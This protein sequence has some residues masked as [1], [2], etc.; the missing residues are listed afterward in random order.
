LGSSARRIY[1]IG[2]LILSP[3]RRLVLEARGVSPIDLAPLVSDIEENEKAGVALGHFLDFLIKSRPKPATEWRSGMTTSLPTMLSNRTLDAASLSA[4]LKRMTAIWRNE[5]EAYPGWLVCPPTDRTHLSL[6]C[7]YNEDLVRRAFEAVSERERAESLYEVAWRRDLAFAPLS[8]WLRDA[9]SAVVTQNTSTL[10]RRQRCEIGAILA[11]DAREERDTSLFERWMA[12]LQT[13]GTTDEDV[14]ATCAYEKSLFARNQLDFSSLTRLIPTIAGQDPIWKIR[15]AALYCDLG[16]AEKAKQLAIE[17]VQEARNRYMRDRKS[18]WNI[19][20]LAWA[21]FLA[22]AVRFTPPQKIVADPLMDSTGWSG[23]LSANECDPWD[24][25]SNLDRE[26]SDAFRSRIDRSRSRRPSFDAGVYS[27]TVSLGSYSTAV[28]AFD[29]LRLPERVGLPS[30]AGLVNVMRSRFSQALELSDTWTEQDLLLGLRIL[31]VSDKLIERL[32][33]RIEVARMPL[34]TVENLIRAIWKAVAFG[35]GRFAAITDAAS[36]NVA[37]YWIERVGV[38]VEILSHLVIHLTGEKAVAAFRE[39]AAL[40]E[41]HDWTC[42]VLFEPLRHLLE[43]SCEAVSPSDL[44]GLVPDIL[45]VPLPDERGI[46][47]ASGGASV[48]NDWPELTQHLPAPTTRPANSAEFTRRVGELIS[49][50]NVGDSLTRERAMVRLGWLCWKGGVLTSTEVASFSEAVWSKREPSGFPVGFQGHPEIFFDFPT[51]D[52]N[53]EL[54]ALFRSSV[55]NSAFSGVI[56]QQTIHAITRATRLR[57]DG[58]RGFE[59]DSDEAVK[60]FDILSVWTPDK[61]VKW[62]MGGDEK[63]GEVIARALAWAV[64]PFITPGAL[65]NERAERLLTAIENGPLNTAVL[66]LPQIVRLQ[67]SYENRAIELIRKAVLDREETPVGYGLGAIHDWHRLSADGVLAAIPQ[68]L[69][70]AVVTKVASA[71]E[72][73]LFDALS[74]AAELVGDSELNENDERELT[75]TLERLRLETAYETWDVSDLR[76]TTLTLVR[77]RCVRL[78]HKLKQKGAIHEAIEWWINETK[79]DPIPEVRYALSQTED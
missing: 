11:R 26:L 31:G 24:E 6:E 20:R 5:H 62:I 66:S 8:P 30:T 60:L 51:A 33:G 41:A 36:Q 32:F 47:L 29:T 67:R 28:A 71:R 25:L 68:K 43:R 3:A 9:L 45:N 44:Q 48:A 70:Q 72:P 35:R 12:F 79:D 39:A 42:W 1:L 58:S 14:L 21:L 18:I 54:R 59:L 38:L 74:V 55:L 37:Q 50:V 64:L 19:S 78:A 7:E 69:R 46:H 22:R 57:T 56:S 4:E 76:T 73:R 13:H 52:K 27:T 2:V 53:D 63:L 23:L 17:A 75:D 16:E 40:S 65:G 49:K 34:A 77:A 61:S 10:S 15:C